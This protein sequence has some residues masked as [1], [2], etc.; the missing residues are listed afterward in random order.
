MNEYAQSVLDEGML[1]PR[2]SGQRPQPEGLGGR[3]LRSADLQRAS[4]ALGHHW[5]GQDFLRGALRAKDPSSFLVS[6]FWCQICTEAPR[7]PYLIC[8]LSPLF[9]PGITPNKSLTLL[10]LCWHLLPGRP[11]AD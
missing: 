11:L 6:L 2:C 7:L 8:P 5:A 3:F 1:P 9:F 4:F 10:T